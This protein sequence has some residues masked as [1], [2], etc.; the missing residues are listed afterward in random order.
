M[1][2][3]WKRSSYSGDNGGNCVEVAAWWQK[4]S[5]SGNNGGDC[6]EVGSVPASPHIPVRDSKR[7]AEHAAPVLRLTRTAF[8]DFLA[9]T[10]RSA[11]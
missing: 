3:S 8:T 11:A 9:A 10:T 6:V 5:H 7:A 4:S 2:M 1:V